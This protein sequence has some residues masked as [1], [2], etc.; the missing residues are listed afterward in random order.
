LNDQ[1]MVRRA[2]Y[3]SVQWLHAVYDGKLLY[4]AGSEA[5]TSG[6]L[7]SASPFDYIAVFHQEEIGLGAGFFTSSQNLVVLTHISQAW[8]PA[9]IIACTNSFSW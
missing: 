1:L 7:Q 8:Q 6:K 4:L 2:L 9:V 3:S 5:H